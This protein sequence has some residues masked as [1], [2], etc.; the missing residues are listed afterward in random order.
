MKV[1]SLTMVPDLDRAASWAAQAEQLG[2]DGVFMAEGKRDPFLS[3][4]RAVATTTRIEVG[5]G[6]ALAFTRSPMQLA[7]TAQELQ[8]YS[9]GRLVLGLGPQVKSHIERRFSAP[10]DP[11]LTRMREYVQALRAIWDC[12]NLGRRL[13]FRGQYYRHNLMIP[14]FTPPPH[15]YGHPKIFLAVT[16]PKMAEL[17]GELADGVIL[18][19]IASPAY[20]RRTILPGLE[21]GLGEAGRHRAELEIVVSPRIATG[22][23]EAT[24][25]RT[26]RLIRRQLA[27]YAS[28]PEYR[29]IMDSHGRVGLQAELA[30]LAAQGKWEAMGTAFDEELLADFAIVAPPEGV[31]RLLR[32]RYGD[33][34]TR[35]SVDDTDVSAEREVWAGILR[36]LHEEAPVHG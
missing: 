23:D 3:L 30:R 24:L 14:M 9:K 15:D 13:D 7:Y 33:F 8:H 1:T 10:F 4:S 31:P 36:H 22:A 19:G 34:C 18:H 11:V 28:T 20:I 32:E 21:R 29:A 5:T 2:F 17:A 16:G 12:W 25:A 26:S 27:F 6:I 35:V